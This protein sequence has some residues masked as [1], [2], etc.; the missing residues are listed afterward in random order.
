MV[1]GTVTGQPVLGWH[2]YDGCSDGVNPETS[3]NKATTLY[4]GGLGDGNYTTIQAAIDNASS[5]DTVFVYDD[6]APYAELIRINTSITLVG[7]TQETTLLELNANN[8]T[9]IIVNADHV[10]ISNLT[11]SIGNFKGAGIGLDVSSHCVVT[12]CTLQGGNLYGTAGIALFGLSSEGTLSGCSNNTISYCTIQNF[13][14]NIVL[15][16][17]CHDNSI[18]KNTIMNSSNFS[19]LLVMSNRT[20]ITMNNFMLTGEIHA[21]FLDALETEWAYNYW[22]TCRGLLPKPIIGMRYVTIINK[23]Y[24]LPWLNFDWHPACT[25]YAW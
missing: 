25:P 7:E 12:N 21:F 4:V 2:S 16:I 18:A 20:Q 13:A 23:G 9:C 8:T 1:L 6:S 19:I 17:A 14:N 3:Q 5:G 11:I 15:A 22:D 24:T 10:T